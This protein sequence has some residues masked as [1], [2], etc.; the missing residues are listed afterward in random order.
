[1]S[2]FVSITTIGFFRTTWVTDTIAQKLE[3]KSAD[4]SRNTIS[5]SKKENKLVY[6]CMRLSALCI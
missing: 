6:Q 2:R 5:M 1:M 4:I 3:C